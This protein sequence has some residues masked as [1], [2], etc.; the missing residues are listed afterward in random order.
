MKSVLPLCLIL[1]ALGQLSAQCIQLQNCPGT[2]SACDL[3]S[4]NDVL[5]NE[6]YWFDPVNQTPD[7]SDA[8]VEASLTLS[9]DCPGASLTLRYLLFLDL[10]NNGTWETVVKSW[11]PPAPGTVNFNNANNPN[12][13]GGDVRNFDERPVPANEQYQ[14]ALETI[15]S[16]NTVQ[17]NLRWVN[18][19]TPNT[20]LIPQLPYGTHKIKWVAEDNLGNNQVC[21]YPIVVKDCKAPTVVCLNGLSVNLMPT[22]VIT[23]W[24]S[25]F[26]QYGEDNATPTPLLE[27]G[28]RKCGT[29]TGF[30]INADGSPLNSVTFSCTEIGTQC[31]ELWVRDASGNADYCETY[32][33]VQDNLDNCPGVGSNDSIPSVQCL[34]GMSVNLGPSGEFQ[35]WAS[36]LLLSAS[37]DNTPY[38]LLEFGLQP[39]PYGNNFPEDGNG[40]PIQSLIFD[41]INLGSQCVQLWVRDQDGLTAYCE[42][43]VIIQDNYNYCPG[44][45]A[46]A[47]TIVCI[48]GLS[49]NIMPT[50]MITLWAT[51]FLQYAVDDDTPT[52]QLLFSLRKSGT[53]AGFPLDSSGIAIQSL[54]YDCSELG[55]QSV[56]LWAKDLDGNADYCETYV[57]VQDMLEVCS[58]GILLGAHAA[59][60]EVRI[61][62]PLPNPTLS[63]A[64]IPIQLAKAGHVRVEISDLSGKILWQNALELNAGDQMIELNAQNMPNAGVYLWQVI[65][66][67]TSASGK[68]IKM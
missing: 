56:E 61:A 18:P 34:N 31:V 52:D 47:P 33:I 25:D 66:G 58:G 55:T 48:N 59:D 6:S 41:C 21:E 32:T 19:L 62:T 29:G 57:I 68:L 60:A 24:A 15:T 54:Q 39:C 7:L 9:D 49:V 64:R 12:Y 22:G 53:G 5:W 10:D 11:E 36:D 4:N 13:E 26:L 43:P 51:D 38:N 67:N 23:L 3:T 28:I 40:N 65:A 44:S 37:D 17:G 30:P 45:G 16:G 63:G 1:M 8:P 46:E 50:G 42:A 20:F 35:L 2:L 14:F 27:Y